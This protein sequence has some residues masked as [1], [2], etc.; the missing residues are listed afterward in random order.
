MSF[1]LLS[2][3]KG[4]RTEVALVIAPYVDPKFM[5]TLVAQMKP[6]RLCLLV[7]DSIRPEDLQAIH[8]Q[9]R[10]RVELEV[11]LARASGVM[12]MKAFYFEFVKEGTSNRRKRRLLFG[13]ANA[14][15]AA[16]HGRRNA[17]LIA[18]ADLAINADSEIADYFSAILATFDVPY[19]RVV[20]HVELALSKAP[21]LYLPKITSVLPGEL[22]SGFDTWLQRGVLAAQ[23]RNAPQFATL[24]IQLK[25]ALP[26][27]LV[28][29][30]FANRS[31]TEKGERNIVRYG[32]LSGFDDLA[33]EGTDLEIPRWKSRYGVWTHLG[34]WISYECYRSHRKSM[35]S[36]ASAARNAKISRILDQGR[37][38]VWREKRIAAL[39]S[40]LEQVWTD[41]IAA[42]VQPGL[43]LDGMNDKLNPALYRQ[44]FIQKLEQDLQLAQDSDF[45]NRYIN[46]YEFP[47]MPRFRQDTTAWENLVR[48]WCES[49]V[50]EA[51]KNRTPSLVARRVRDVLEEK[52][53]SLADLGYPSIAGFLRTH[54][55]TEWEGEELTLGEWIIGYHDY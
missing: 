33:V 2:V 51:A 42:D 37:D 52:G 30:I 39:L 32:Y 45:R 20:E 47:D 15:D 23:Y 1:D 55:A 12:H 29:R 19:T 34:D 6:N 31:F 18:Q 54:W 8:G 48:S 27:D 4:Y 11:R 38:T 22:P 50:V 9:R 17:E 5:G 44:R 14:T 49:I 25:K 28:T 26:Q 16:F 46:G 3:P 13:S 21:V 10:R 24:N 53:L 7:D 43:Y 40:A 35:K 36:K 41:L